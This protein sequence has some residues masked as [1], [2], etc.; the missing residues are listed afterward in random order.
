MFGEYLPVQL[1][2]PTK[3]S[4]LVKLSEIWFCEGFLLKGWPCHLKVYKVWETPQ[5]CDWLTHDSVAKTEIC[6]SKSFKMKGY[7]SG[8]T[9]LHSKLEFTPTK[10]ME[11]KH[12]NNYDS[13]LWENVWGE[14]F[15]R[16]HSTKPRPLKQALVKHVYQAGPS[17]TRIS[18]RP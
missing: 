15:K 6:W 8:P 12:L 2:L 14:Y 9:T 16:E 17:K 10:R 13:K 11:E 5:L 4:M 1:W 3:P 7:K 18:S